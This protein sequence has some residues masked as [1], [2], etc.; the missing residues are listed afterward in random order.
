MERQ[1]S[2]APSMT[3]EVSDAELEEDQRGCDS[4]HAWRDDQPTDLHRRVFVAS[5]QRVE[6]VEEVDEYVPPP[7]KLQWRLDEIRAEFE[8]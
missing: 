2:A 7:C 1:P 5:V 8:R 4:Y 6:A 3:Y